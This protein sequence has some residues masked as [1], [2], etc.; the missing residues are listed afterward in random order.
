MAFKIQD[1]T[2]DVLPGLRAQCPGLSCRTSDVGD[3]PDPKP[4]CADPSCKPSGASEEKVYI[5]SAQAL[6]ALRS[7][8]RQS[9]GRI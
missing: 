2:V 7:Q 1:L 8:M 9:L 6:T 4:A 5:A 3:A